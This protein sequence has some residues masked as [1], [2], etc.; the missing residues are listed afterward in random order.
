MAPETS[1]HEVISASVPPQ[2]P[3]EL[4]LMKSHF[5]A[6]LHHEI[7]TPL[8]GILGMTDLLLET[9]LDQEQQEYVTATRLCAESL[10]EV[11][12]ATLEFSALSAGHVTL[13]D[14]E[15][16]LD[17][18]LRAAVAE[19]AMQ[20][21]A[22]GIDLRL[23]LADD[24]PAV[25][26]G[27][28]V[29]LRQ[30]LAHLIGNA[31]KF[32]LRG[33]V[34]VLARGAAASG[35]RYSLTVT[36]RDS[37]IGIAPEK[38]S[39]IFE[40]FRQVESGLARAYPGLG[41]GLAITQKLV[42]LMGGEIEVSSRMNAGSTFQITVPVRLLREAG[43]AEA[44]RAV[45]GDRPRILVVEDNDVAQRVVAHIL[46]RGRYE[47]D[48]VDGGEAAVQAAAACVYDLILMDLQMPGVDGL[49]AASRIRRLP[50]CGSVPI[51]AFTANSSAESREL[52][53]RH[54]MNGFLAKPVQ[55]EELLASLRR[56]I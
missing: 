44:G 10:M 24:L 4:A 40:S 18:T 14:S 32:T 54:G 50:S 55:G 19:Y 6:S 23:T 15:F 3:D 31:I 1:Q 26:A 8:S 41:L 7:R 16:H 49:E 17:E 37:G 33:G 2:T 39:V 53:R 27:D 25:V 52:C 30:A 28:A 46:R 36:V 43:A 48:C 51:V 29:R 11:L 56:L 45:R 9:R 42:H 21:E 38:L 20:A 35:E 47:F 13:E 34:E 22:K 12:N 5:L